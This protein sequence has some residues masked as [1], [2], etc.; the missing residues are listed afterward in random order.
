V[1]TIKSKLNLHQKN[2]DQS[3]KTLLQRVYIK[4]MST[5]KYPNRKMYI[6]ASLQP[7]ED[8]T[9][10]A[11]FTDGVLDHELLGELA[12]V[13]EKR[14]SE[15]SWKLVTDL[16]EGVVGP[17][18]GESRK[19]KETHGGFDPTTKGKGKMQ[20]RDVDEAD[21][22]APGSSD[23]QQ[24]DH[25]ESPADKQHREKR[26]PKKTFVPYHAGY[27]KYPTLQEL[28]NFV[29]EHGVM[30]MGKIP[31]SNISQL[32]DV[33]VYDDSIIKIKSS[34]DDSTPTMYKA[35]KNMAQII[36]L[37][38]LEKRAQDR[39]L[40][41]MKR[42][43]AIR[44]LEIKNLGNGGMTEIPCGRCPVF[45]MCEVGGPVNPSNCEYFDEWFNLLEDNREHEGHSLAW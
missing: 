34:P 19:R 11:W 15:Q 28:T 41:E 6:L 45:D 14:I 7:G 21:D 3:I 26:R 18:A 9:G 10:G 29:N 40:D 22:N 13:L 42:M 37:G 17:Q 2:V 44:E 35:R 25:D 1:K 33:M 20:R 32:L 36:D 38:A 5:V 24:D 8:A 27:A 4:S 12:T 30:Q 16:D 39:N 23:A 31:Q 43:K